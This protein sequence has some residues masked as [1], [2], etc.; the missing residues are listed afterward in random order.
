M[1][2]WPKTAFL[3]LLIIFDKR[4]SHLHPT[5]NAEKLA[6]LASFITMDPFGLRSLHKDV[7]LASGCKTKDADIL[8]REL[9]L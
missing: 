1:T 4:H 6:Q 3:I 8:S 5:S 7:G 2:G 9:I